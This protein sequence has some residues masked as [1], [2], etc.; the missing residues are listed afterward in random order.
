VNYKWIGEIQLDQD[1]CNYL[2]KDY[3][4]M[5]TWSFNKTLPNHKINNLEFKDKTEV[6]Y[7]MELKM[8]AKFK[9]EANKMELQYKTH[10]SKME[11]QAKTE[12]LLE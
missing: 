11:E 3:H 1:Y 10:Q 7:K 12:A 8:E 4:F 9:M 2:I 6:K 5:E